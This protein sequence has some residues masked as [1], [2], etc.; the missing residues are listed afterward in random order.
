MTQITTGPRS[1]GALGALLLGLRAMSRNPW[2]S[3][4]FV[5][6]T[7]VQGVLQG[8]LIWALRK[9]LLAF[10]SGS[11]VSM[12]L[13]VVGIF[14]IW[15]LLSLS[16][17][18]AEVVSIAL[19]HRVEIST[20][21]EVLAKLLSLSVSF[22]D[23][24]SQGNFV[25]SS[26]YDLKGI[27]GVTLEVG[28]I[29]LYGSRLAG[30]VVAAWVMSPKL[31]FISMVTV[32][33]G[34]IPAYWLGR[35]ITAAAN[36]E[37]E[38]LTT[39]Y[40]SFFQV[41][42][43]IRIIKSNCGERNVMDQAKT[44]G[45]ELYIQAMRQAETRGLA[46][47]LLELVSGVGLILVLT[48]GGHDVAA[49]KLQW[50]SLMG[51]LIAVLAVYAPV[52]GLLQTYTTIRSVIPNLDR[53]ESIMQATP[54]VEDQP[55]AFALSAPPRTIELRNVSFTYNSELILNSINATFHSGETIGIVGPSGAG[56]STL[57]ALLL[58]FYDPTEGSILV[59]GVDLR[60]IRHSDWM[61]LSAVVLQEPFL[62]VDTIANNIK[63][64]RPDASVEEVTSAATAANLHDEILLMDEGYESRIGRRKDGRL[65]SG[66]QQQRV[67]IAAAL[68]K[69]API[70]FLDEATSSLDSV[71]EEKVQRAIDTLMQGRTTFVI[72]HRLSTLRNADRVM[73]L[74]KGR[75]VGLG[76]H[77]ELL[78]HC[79]VYQ[80][81][82]GSQHRYFADVSDT[83]LSEI[84]AVNA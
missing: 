59:D 23:R 51:L 34:A 38:V 10:S 44:I 49:G 22:Y 74:D 48:I 5:A 55:N 61:K 4:Y 41:S 6:S 45:H 66:G 39:L 60:S 52:V 19:G 50:Q 15:L 31:A 40:D 1:N 26:Y 53:V 7:A 64:A 35:R 24:N 29:V 81:L 47:L 57:I 30:L 2:L 8:L 69:N 18:L 78:A 16:A 71:S 12:T 33:L 21:Q 17:H 46:R 75:L 83:W 3:I 76:N 67:C 28:K 13:V 32:P 37:R 72:A 27:R 14:A 58:R 80:E 42:S 54:A 63:M 62:F 84:K 79:R 25:M 56:K 68:L 70:L 65:L 82:W 9:A 11:D 36:Q 77:E 73:V 20:M 43:G